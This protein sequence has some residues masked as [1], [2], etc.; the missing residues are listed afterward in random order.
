MM[1]GSFTAQEFGEHGITVN[2]YSPGLIDTPMSQFFPLFNAI[3]HPRLQQLSRSKPPM[4]LARYQFL[5]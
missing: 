3:S 2:A 4:G 1:Q 5:P